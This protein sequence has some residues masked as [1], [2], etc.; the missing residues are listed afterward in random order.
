MI[1]IKPISPVIGAEVIGA[2]LRSPNKSEFNK[3]K[4]ALG[5]HSVLFFRD[6][7]LLSPG[8]QVTFATQFGPLHEHPAAPTMENNEAIFV[9][10]TDSNSKV[11]N[12]NGWHTDVSC[13]KE[14]PLVTM[15]QLHEVPEL[16]GDTLFSSMYAA[17]ETLS[18]KLKS[19]VSK[20][21][22]HH[23]S[24]HVYRGRYSDRG[25]TDKTNYP[26]SV[27]PVVATHPISGRPALYV[28]PSF[29]T[30]IEGL[31]KT[32]SAALLELLFTHQSRLEFQT[33]FQWTPNSIALWD[34]R[35]AQHFAIWDYWPQPRQGH[36]VT[37]K[38]AAPEKGKQIDSKSYGNL[39]LSRSRL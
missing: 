34:N 5:Q 22:A 17:Y 9:I 23:E 14:P 39:R 19:F 10:K 29:T 15:L 7:P 6:Q 27:H 4:E 13:D 12:G 25:V 26:R 36:R 24:E 38:G 8:E 30:R 11:A 18:P 21:N 20:L 32:E 33:R 28:N 3:I 16:G 35:S 37:I 1:K 31:S 2:D